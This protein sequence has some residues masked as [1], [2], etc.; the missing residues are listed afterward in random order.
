MEHENQSKGTASHRVPHLEKEID[1]MRKAIDEMRENM[2][3]ENLVE[4]LVH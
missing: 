2:R 4:E 3:R 1:Q